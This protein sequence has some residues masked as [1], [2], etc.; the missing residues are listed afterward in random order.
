MEDAMSNP[1]GHAVFRARAL[2]RLALRRTRQIRRYGDFDDGVR[3]EL[4]EI[5]YVLTDLDRSVRGLQQKHTGSFPD[6]DAILYAG[7][8]ALVLL[9]LLA[10]CR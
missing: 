5:E 9:E 10:A 3:A 4:D 7:K 1:N 6:R 8:L 2:V